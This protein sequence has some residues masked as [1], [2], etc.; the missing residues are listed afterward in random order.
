MF[1]FLWQTC[2]VQHPD[3]VYHPGGVSRSAGN[4]ADGLGR[5]HWRLLSPDQRDC[6]REAG[7]HPRYGTPTL[8][9]VWDHP[10][11]LVERPAELGPLARD[12]F[13]PREGD[14]ADTADRRIAPNPA[15]S[16]EVSRRRSPDSFSPAHG[17]RSVTLP[18]PKR[19]GHC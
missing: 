3:P 2:S 6:E 17:A 13:A 7:D 10:G 1:P 11:V 14:Q 9:V 19:T 5:A 15:H 4:D 12:A 18:F 16:P 8:P